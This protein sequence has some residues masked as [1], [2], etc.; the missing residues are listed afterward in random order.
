MIDFKELPQDGTS[1]EQ[2]VRE[3]FLLY[4]LHPQWTGKGPDQGRD[5]LINEKV[6]GQL[7]VF[8]RRWLVQC[9]HFAHSGKSVG[10]SD[11]GSILN[12]C[13][14]VGASGYLLV[15]STQP[16]S[17]LVTMLKEISEQPENNIVTSIWDGVDLEKSLSEPRCFSLGHLFFPKSFSVI[18]WKLFN[19]GSPN[20]WTA[21]YKTYFLHLNSRISGK[22]PDLGDVN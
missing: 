20:K 1:F 12:D 14:Q 22:H 2:F 13:K 3:I 5:I 4:D 19:T 17:S 15:C 10:R 18:P 7:S 21:N 8:N 11:I 6:S 9:K 16:S